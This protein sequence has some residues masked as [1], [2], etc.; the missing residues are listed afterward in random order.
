[1]SIR[2]KILAVDDEELNLD[3]I[4]HHLVRSGY[5]VVRA[6]DG[7]VA[8]QRLE[9]NTDIETI[10]LDRM[11]PNL[12]GMDFLERIKKDARFHDIPVVMQTAAAASDQVL[13]GIKAGVYYYLTKPYEGAILIGIVQAALQEAATKR[14]LRE[15]VCSY[16]RILGLMRR[17][18]FHFRTLE[19]AANLAQYVAN[20]FPE[21]EKVVF[22]LHE[23][24]L[25]AVE[26]GNLGITYAEKSKLVKSGEWSEEIKRRLNSNEYRGKFASLTF[27]ATPEAI[28]V[29]IKDQG[30]GFDWREYLDFSPSRA[31]HP[32]GRGIAA[33]RAMSF[34]DMEYLGC[35]N[36]V[37]CTI[38]LAK[39]GA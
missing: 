29:H 10:V 1:M 3:I 11:M 7:N 24:T 16:S 20:C 37:R 34:H 18:C 21:P 32:H 30:E 9:E 19:D 28:V 38:K 17:A 14:I 36:E 35:G 27:E 25:N 15:R 23:L 39:T 12:G 6:E 2:P 5:E 33:S 8:L 4:E 26:H 22:G 31:T 13:E